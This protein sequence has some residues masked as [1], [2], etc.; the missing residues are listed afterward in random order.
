MSISFTVPYPG[1]YL[2]DHSHELGMIPLFDKWEDFLTTHPNFA[3]KHLSLGKINSLVAD[4]IAAL[5]NL[6][7]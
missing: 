5:E 1:T 6:R 7:G 4:M 3:T 2:Y